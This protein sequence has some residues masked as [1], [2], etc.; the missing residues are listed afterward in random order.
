MSK[1][2]RS[3]KPLVIKQVKFAKAEDPASRKRVEE[4]YKLLLAPGKGE[5]KG[6]NNEERRFFSENFK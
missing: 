2:L 4:V 6:E 3:R 1:I 5:R